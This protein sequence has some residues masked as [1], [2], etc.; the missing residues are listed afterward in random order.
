MCL[1][2]R[3]KFIPSVW[4]VIQCYFA[5]KWL[6]LISWVFMR[7]FWPRCKSAKLLASF[8]GSSIV[9]FKVVLVCTTNSSLL[10][11][12]SIAVPGRVCSSINS[13]LCDKH[14]GTPQHISDCYHYQAYWQRL[15]LSPFPAACFLSSNIPMLCQ[16]ARTVL[17]MERRMGQTLQDPSS[18]QQPPSAFS[19]VF[20]I[21]G[22][23]VFISLLTR[24]G[25][26]CY[27]ELVY[28]SL[29]HSQKD[30]LYVIMHT[31]WKYMGKLRY[32][33]THS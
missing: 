3:N 13:L 14:L 25:P 7:L 24:D 27:S 2:G 22:S 33:A 12:L 18:Q 5:L 21:M 16:P 8:F 4:S 26:F 17:F 31:P 20:F 23:N 15:Q 28:L 19:L 1:N 29:D 32:S 9:W 6:I 30:V 10:K 11:L